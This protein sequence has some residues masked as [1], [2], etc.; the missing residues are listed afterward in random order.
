MKVRE[1]GWLCWL[2]VALA[3]VPADA[4]DVFVEGGRLVDPRTGVVE[5]GNLLIVDG[6]IVGRPQERPLGFLG[7]VVDARGGWVLP[8]LRDMHVHTAVSQAPGALERVGTTKAAQRM[9]RAGVVGFLDL[10]NAEDLI[11]GVRDRQRSSPEQEA[12]RQADI[13]AAGPCLTAT[14]GHCTEY[15]TPTRVIDTPKQAREQ[16]SELARKRPD[17]V[18]LV[19]AHAT[20][21]AKRL[22][23]PT[24]DRETFR[25]ALR[26]ADER[27][28]PTVVHIRSWRD[29][30][31]AVEEGAT[32]IT[33]LPG[34]PAPEGI[35]RLFLESGTVIIPTMALGDVALARDKERL[36]DPLLEEIASAR[37]LEAYRSFDLEAP[38]QEGLRRGLAQAQSHRAQTLSRLAAAGVPIVAGTDAGNWFTVHGYSLHR[39]LE[40]YVE[41]GLTPLQALRSATVTAG[42][43]LGRGW[44]LSAGDQG[45]V[46][47]LEA[48]P[49]DDIRNTRRIRAVVHHGRVVPDRKLTDRARF[50]RDR[51]E[52][53]RRAAQRGERSAAAGVGLSARRTRRSQ[54]RWGVVTSHRDRGRACA[55]ARRSA[56]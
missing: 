8:G 40:L 54:A 18:K 16:V 9:L 25:A 34:G 10:F 1:S 3:G 15:P 11:L 14:N 56:R 38:E 35:E 6:R 21:G 31:D 33:H 7:E 52:L 43:L 47:V 13:Y 45:S 22:A 4:Q 44:G 12:F 30:R 23:R 39:E 5:A 28:L 26:A 46:L 42:D 19:Y 50:E 48:S 24:L 55:R 29:V 41:A 53:E 37:I 2:A 32:A 36:D 49:L 20:P 17:V 51:I 27:E